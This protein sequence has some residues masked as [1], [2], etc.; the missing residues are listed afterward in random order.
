MLDIGSGLY[1]NDTLDY[2]TNQELRHLWEDKLPEPFDN[3]EFDLNSMSVKLKN[4][5]DNK[6]DYYNLIFEPYEII[7]RSFKNVYLI[8]IENMNDNNLVV[9]EECDYQTLNQIINS[10]IKTSIPSEEELKKAEI[11]YVN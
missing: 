3:Y 7:I 5:W 9:E 4:I 1:T 6:D 10:F 8:A 11:N 2:K